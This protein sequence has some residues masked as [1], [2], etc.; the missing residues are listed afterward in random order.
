MER[1]Q[2]KTTNQSG[3]VL[4]MN[5]VV[6]T[7]VLAGVVTTF[8]Y[9]AQN[10]KQSINVAQQTTRFSDEL[11]ALNILAGKIQ[12]KK[13][14]SSG[15]PQ[16]EWAPDYYP[17]ESE[18]NNPAFKPYFSILKTAQTS[19][20]PNLSVEGRFEAGI[21]QNLPA[22][23]DKVDGRAQ[24]TD[25]KVT[26]FDLDD[27]KLG[28]LEKGADL[29]GWSSATQQ[30]NQTEEQ[31][32]FIG[33]PALST[34]SGTDSNNYLD[35]RTVSIPTGAIRSKPFTIHKI[36]R[37]S[38]EPLVMSAIEVSVGGT[39]AQIP[40][41]PPPDP[42]CQL[43][44]KIAPRGQIC[45]NQTSSVPS[46]QTSN[47]PV[48]SITVLRCTPNAGALYLPLYPAVGSCPPP[49]VSVGA[50]TFYR[51]TNPIWHV[52]LGP[53]PGY[54]MVRGMIYTTNPGQGRGASYGE[55]ALG[56]DEL[57]GMYR[58]SFDQLLQELGQPTTQTVT[59]TVY[60]SVTTT[61]CRTNETPEC[62]GDCVE[63]GGN[64]G[65]TAELYIDS[66]ASLAQV[67][68][69]GFRTSQN[70]SLGRFKTS[71]LGKFNLSQPPTGTAVVL[72][73]SNL[74][75][76][77]P[78]QLW[79]DASGNIDDTHGKWTV[80]GKVKGL[81]RAG[82]SQNCSADFMVYPPPPPR[83]V[84]S[85]ENPQILAGQSTTV[86]LNCQG[87][88]K[89]TSARIVGGNAFPINNF[90]PN[91]KIATT[92][93]KR[94]SLVAAQPIE[95]IV[96]GPGGSVSVSTQLGEVCEYN[97]PLAIYQNWGRKFKRVETTYSEGSRNYL[98]RSEPQGIPLAFGIWKPCGRNAFCI[99]NYQIVP[100]ELWWNP[101]WVEI[102]PATSPNCGLLR[103]FTRTDGCFTAE[104]QIR[105]ADGSDRKISSLKE[106]DFVFNPLFK[107]PVR[108]SKIVKGPEKR[109]LYKV[110][111]GKN[112]LT[113]TEDHPFLTEKGWVRADELVSGQ[114]VM[115]EQQAKSVHSVK[116]LPYEKPEDVYNFELDTD[117]PEGHI[118]LANGIPTGDLTTQKAVKSMVK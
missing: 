69:D 23:I 116:K 18:F 106:N 67:S 32:G 105:I 8:Q 75:S 45:Y 63:L 61:V 64:R 92:Q 91:S 47:I 68:G 110:V 24:A 117:V 98:T 34:L 49:M 5:L 21:C 27:S 58:V 72:P 70:F 31:K 65:V 54:F 43:K 80:S 60:N 2:K 114:W 84:I 87:S 118:V 26:T 71:D 46:T 99:L 37:S 82:T 100:N 33:Y 66:P 36:L 88:S 77:Q 6:G 94:T 52:N 97:N 14:D 79:V 7:I 56:R 44:T 30:R 39:R 81:T 96:T 50:T 113:V 115:G 48:D 42:S 57:E 102:G 85:V 29:T 41:A 103:T 111:I 62:S 19:L 12:L 53:R 28:S 112:R 95:A 108:I 17:I 86:T 78:P 22:R 93:F 25:C 89:I 3:N 4:V 16:T 40:I 1:R 20:V 9:I 109:S 55:E 38:S 107:I 35:G 59:S 73:P 74:Y 15:N 101:T 83:C 104:T 11:L 51:S 13:A 90:R 10:I 76:I